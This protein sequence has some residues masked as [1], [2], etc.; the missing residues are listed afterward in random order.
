MSGIWEGDRLE[1]VIASVVI[2]LVAVAVRLAVGRL[3]RRQTWA[4]AEVG[5]RWM[6][7]VRNMTL[8]VAFI[9]LIVVWAQELRTVALSL[10]AFAVA[11]VIA[12]KEM[13]MAVGGSFSRATSGSFAVGDRVRI[14]THRGDVIDHSLLTTTLLEIGPGHIRTG[15]TLVIPNNVLLTDAV[16]NETAGHGYVLHSFA[17]PVARQEWQ[18]ARTVLLDAAETHSA[19]YVEDA[20]R[21]MERRARE[22]SLTMPMVDPFVLAKPA[23]VDT[24]ELTVRVPVPAREAWWVENEILA[25]WL[26][27][28]DPPGTDTASGSA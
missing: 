4:S 8:L 10:V 2:I 1:N 21:E 25:E 22:H 6:I 26:R 9:A 28:S 16:A 19:E 15:R 20:R 11:G 5:R 18:R 14:G 24:V 3:V 17:V 23:G 13:I 27:R 12:M 7:Q